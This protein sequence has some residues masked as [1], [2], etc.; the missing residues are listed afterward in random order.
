MNMT[1]IQN[2]Y[3]IGANFSKLAESSSAQLSVAAEYNSPLKEA[4]TSLGMPLP[5]Q[6]FSCLLSPRVMSRQHPRQSNVDKVL[7]VIK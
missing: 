4:N 1:F 5:A 7:N 6:V 2:I 3:R